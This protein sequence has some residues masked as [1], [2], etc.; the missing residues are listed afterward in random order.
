[1]G[2]KHIIVAIVVVLVAAAF[3]YDRI[4]GLRAMGVVEMAYG[5]WAIWI[6]RVPYGDPPRGHLTGVSAVVVGLI[7]VA[8]GLFFVLAPKVVDDLLSNA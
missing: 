8:L 2:T 4:L 3:L 5:F 1:V 7:A 6:R